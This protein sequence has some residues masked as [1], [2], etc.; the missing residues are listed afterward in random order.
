MLLPWRL[1]ARESAMP[2]SDT[3]D[4]KQRL[5][6]ALSGISTSEMKAVRAEVQAELDTLPHTPIPPLR[7][8]GPIPPPPAELVEN[9][10]AQERALERRQ[11]PR[12]SEI[13]DLKSAAKVAADFLTG[14]DRISDVLML[15]VLKFGRAST[16]MRAVVAGI[17]LGVVFLGGNLFLVWNISVS[18]TALQ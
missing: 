1:L 7:S 15:L 4:S 11:G 17:I 6:R 16:L 13:E 8:G 5:E 14:M 10:K 3:P 9:A 2:E 18:Q 12:D